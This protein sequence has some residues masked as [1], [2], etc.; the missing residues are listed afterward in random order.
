MLTEISVQIHLVLEISDYA[1]MLMF[2][3]YTTLTLKETETVTASNPI[4][5][6][7]NNN[8]KGH[9]I[10]SILGNVHFSR[11]IKTNTYLH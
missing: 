4:C 2:Q 5:V 3:P 6:L 11:E 9:V 7:Q 8:E 10:H 1:Q